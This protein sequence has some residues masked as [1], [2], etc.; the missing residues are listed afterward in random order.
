MNLRKLL[1]K[2]INGQDFTSKYFEKYGK[3]I[4]NLA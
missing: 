2:D 3:R 1:L 4:Y